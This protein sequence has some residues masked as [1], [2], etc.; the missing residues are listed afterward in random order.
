MAIPDYQSIMLPLLKYLANNKENALKECVAE[1]ANV[2]KLSE[3]EKNQLLP[4]GGQAVIHNRTGWAKTYLVK[5]GLITPTRRGFI[6]I[7][8]EGQKVLKEN[9]S[10]IDQK[11]L[12]RFPSFAEF[13]NRASST[14]SEPVEVVNFE[15][16]EELI[17][18]AH[19]QLKSALANEILGKIKG[20]T[21]SFFERLVVDLLLKMGYGGSRKNAGQALGQSGDEGVDGVISEDKLGLDNLYIQAK[22]WENTVG[23]PDI[24]KFVG[25]LTGQRSKKGIF[26]TTS[27]FTKDAS[28]YV[29]KID[30]KVVLIDGNTLAT[31]MIDHNVGVSTV[32]TYEVKKIDSDYFNEE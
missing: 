23:R 20:C 16:P 7:S 11:F 10:K 14:G 12:M 5:A 1:I 27:N 3:Q 28:D 18:S 32:N 9:P 21:P 19:G 6:K 30:T 13:Q 17:E 24:Q 2:F 31:L 22:R 4:S 8:D 26:I 15:T 25:A 29:Q